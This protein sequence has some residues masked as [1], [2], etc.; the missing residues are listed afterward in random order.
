MTPDE[1]QQLW[2]DPT[3]WN[4]DGSYQCRA[5]PR[6]HVPKRNGGGWTLSMEH[7]KAQWTIWAILI[8]VIGVAVVVALVARYRVAPTMP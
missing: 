7:P 3:H 8:V 4:R 5:D 2:A 1:P 6:L